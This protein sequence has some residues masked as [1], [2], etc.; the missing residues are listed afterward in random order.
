MLEAVG[1]E[2]IADPHVN[3]AVKVTSLLA[4]RRTSMECSPMVVMP[5]TLYFAPKLSH[6]CL[7]TWILFKPLLSCKD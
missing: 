6:N 5:N 2:D 4:R 7:M 1:M 3:R